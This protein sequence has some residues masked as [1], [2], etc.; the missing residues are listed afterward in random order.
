MPAQA[1]TAITRETAREAASAAVLRLYHA[2][3]PASHPDD[4]IH[5]YAVRAPAGSRLL[6]R[7]VGVAVALAALAGLSVGAQH[8]VRSAIAGSGTAA[9][10]NARLDD[11]YYHCLTVQVDSLV[12]PGRVVDVST[13]NA[14]SWATLS[15]VVAP[16]DTMTT[17]AAGAVA[18]LAL[19]P[20]QGAGGCLG[21]VVQARYR[22]G[23]V[24]YATG[25][26]L[27]GAGPPPPVL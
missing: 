22:N 15:K 26:T 9:V 11:S 21:S 13:S 18:V 19:A 20:R 4:G 1:A 23:Q 12:G 24:R 3:D 25:A 7:V 5:L 2:G 14:G 27:Q 6:V 16:R 8:S 10:D 17:D